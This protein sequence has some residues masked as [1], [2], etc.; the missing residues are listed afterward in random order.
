MVALVHDYLLT[1]RGAER[2]F[3]EIA[4]CWPGAPVYT[5]LYDHDAVGDRLA[6]HAITTSGLRHLRASSTNFRRLLPVLPRA[7]ESLPL[8]DRSLVI[9]SSSAFAHG[10]R[11]AGG[12]THVCYCHTPFRYVWHEHRR[13]V[14]EAPRFARGAL[15]IVLGRIRAWDVEASRRV[16]HYVANSR[17][18]QR[19]VAECY[20]RDS[21]VIHPP[22]DVGR[23]GPVRPPE[24]Y[25]VFVGEV[26]THKRV[27]WAVDAA[28]AAGVRLKVVGDGPDRRRLAARATTG[29]EFL[30]R[31]GDE[32]LRE[33]MAAARALVVPNVEEFGIAAVEAMAAGRPVVAPAAGGTLETVVDGTTGV[34]YDPESPAQIAEILRDVDFGRF[35]GSAI[36]AHARR[37]SAGR[38]RTELSAYVERVTA[39]AG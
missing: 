11:P 23:F 5:A 19:R 2:T 17:L 12:A 8:G 34:L 7:I 14:D 33:L 25:F 31:V 16:T 29:V 9:S 22:V 32:E 1:P 10:V 28:R 26:T 18:T 3:A 37:F 13:A 20:G 39:G 4:A 15:S 24:D 6:G 27:E 21:V 38:F 36:A 30:G 35:D